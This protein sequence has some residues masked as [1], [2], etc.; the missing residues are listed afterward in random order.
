MS[1]ASE[2]KSEVFWDV[3]KKIRMPVG[4]N[5]MQDLRPLSKL[6]LVPSLV[7]IRTWLIRAAREQ[8]W[9]LRAYNEKLQTDTRRWPKT[10]K[11]ERLTSY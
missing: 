1:S 5:A 9:E 4:F 11:R 2:Q 7:D 3:V 10:R 6:R 8:S